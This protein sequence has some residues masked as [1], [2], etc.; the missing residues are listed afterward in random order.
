MRRERKGNEM[1]YKLITAEDSESLAKE[2]NVYID[3]GFFP[4]GGVSV[5]QTHESWENERNGDEGVYYFTIL[6][7]AMAF[8]PE[9]TTG[10]YEEKN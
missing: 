6:A 1:E 2:V 5:S 7:Q 8:F 9:R 4:L 10:T 3:K